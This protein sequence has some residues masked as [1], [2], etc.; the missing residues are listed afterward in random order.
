MPVIALGIYLP[1]LVLSVAITLR[2]MW[3]YVLSVLRISFGLMISHWL[4]HMLILGGGFTFSRLRQCA[5]D[6]SPQGFEVK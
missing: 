6:S 5:G 2:E 3:D 1:G 4:T